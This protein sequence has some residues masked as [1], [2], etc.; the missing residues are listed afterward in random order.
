VSYARV[1]VRVMVLVVQVRSIY[2]RYTY[3]V[4]RAVCVRA[5]AGI[6]PLLSKG[7][8]CIRIVID[9]GVCC[10]LM[11]YRLDWAKLAKLNDD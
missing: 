7:G 1:V 8:P 11:P 10:M 2:V 5:W 9:L 6:L 3:L 4:R